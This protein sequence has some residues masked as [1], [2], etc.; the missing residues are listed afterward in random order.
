MKQARRDDKALAL[1]IN[2]VGFRQVKT[3]KLAG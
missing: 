3:N 2:L 1:A